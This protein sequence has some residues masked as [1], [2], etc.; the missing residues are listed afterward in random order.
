M[1]Q[2]DSEAQLIAQAVQGDRGAAAKLFLAHYQP[3]QSHIQ[4]ELSGLRLA[5]VGADDV[6]QQTF[7][8]ASQALASFRSEAAGSFRAWLKTI[9]TNLIKD[10]QRKRRV[11][12]RAPL[13]P[14]GESQRIEQPAADG[15]NSLA[16]EITSP[17]G[18][19]Q[20]RERAQRLL[21]ALVKLPRDQRDVIERYY[22]HNQSWS[23]I[24][25]ETGKSLSALRGICYRGRTTLRE[26]LGGSSLYFSK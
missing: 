6:L 18:G 4:A 19:A 17:S 2:S 15:W 1:S 8:R 12:R 7:A 9:A 16:A 26:L 24:S 20:R 10:A 14:A 13:D 3:L 5:T 11:E 22:L 25:S 23:Q 21:A